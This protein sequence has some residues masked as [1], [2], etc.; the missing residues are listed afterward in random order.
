MFKYLSLLIKKE[1][2]KERRNEGRK[3]GREGGKEREERKKSV[4]FCLPLTWRNHYYLEFSI[5]YPWQNITYMI[6]YVKGI[7]R[8]ALAGVGQLVGVSFCKSKC[9]GFDSCSRHTPGLLVWYPVGSHGGGRGRMFLSHI[10]VSLFLSLPSLSLKSIS[11]SSSENNKKRFWELGM[12]HQSS[13]VS[14]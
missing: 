4:F 9:C 10:H 3:E 12:T 13:R 7:V 11:M 1:E 14:A 5:I 8:S 6:Y 2:I